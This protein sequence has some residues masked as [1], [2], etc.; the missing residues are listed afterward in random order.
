MIEFLSNSVALTIRDRK[1]TGFARDNT[2]VHITVDRHG[3]V[4]LDG[5]S[6]DS[7]HRVE[8]IEFLIEEEVAEW[9]AIGPEDSELFLTDEWMER[10][11]PALRALPEDW[12]KVGE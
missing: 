9:R 12:Q 8:S 5:R 10:F 1:D 7:E 4:Q 2:Y 11:A 3:Y 6:G